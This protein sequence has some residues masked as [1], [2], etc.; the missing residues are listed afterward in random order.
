MSKLLINTF[1]SI[2]TVGALLGAPVFAQ[3]TAD[4]AATAVTA[5]QSATPS[6]KEA[7]SPRV[8]LP[9]HSEWMNIKQ[10]YEALEKA[11]YKTVYSIKSSRYG[12]VAKALDAEN[13]LVRLVIHPTDGSVTVYE[14][15]QRDGQRKPHRA[16]QKNC[17]NDA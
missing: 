6:M 3:S 15:R 11:G 4:T 8:E 10:A 7:K 2:A 17:D 14:K 16:H 13:K 5:P 12:Y 1:A 9:N